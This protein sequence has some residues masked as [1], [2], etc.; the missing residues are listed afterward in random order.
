[1]LYYAENNFDL[2]RG[3][4]KGGDREWTV[5]EWRQYLGNH[6][7]DVRNVTV[8]M[9]VHRPNDDGVVPFPD[10]SGIMW[11]NAKFLA[12]GNLQFERSEAGISYCVCD[13]REAAGNPKNQRKDGRR[14][15]DVLKGRCENRCEWVREVECRECG[16]WKLV[17][18]SLEEIWLSGDDC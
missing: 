16:Q 13:L 6:A 1:M 9:R 11:V 7:Q 5:E 14:I 4:Y 17:D 2:G 3:Q 10:M 18:F 8:G 12:D 15:L